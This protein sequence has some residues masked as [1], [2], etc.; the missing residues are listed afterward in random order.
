MALA[1][2]FSAWQHLQGLPAGG[3]C[4]RWRELV[5]V[6]RVVGPGLLVHTQTN[7]RDRKVTLGGLAV[8]V[9]QNSLLRYR[10]EREWGSASGTGSP[11]PP[12]SAYLLSP[13]P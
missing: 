10:E 6:P 8:S 3:S 4:R 1:Q 9:A 2:N 11:T 12:N 7:Q 5:I 13:P